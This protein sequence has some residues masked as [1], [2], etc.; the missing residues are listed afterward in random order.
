MAKR[1]RGPLKATDAE[2]DL[3]C[4]FFVFFEQILAWTVGTWRRL[5]PALNNGDNREVRASKLE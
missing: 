4:F 1:K 2:Q 3:G 5:P